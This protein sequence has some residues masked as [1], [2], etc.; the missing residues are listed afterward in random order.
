MVKYTQWAAELI[1]LKSAF[2]IKRSFELVILQLWLFFS[3]VT[4]M[5]LIF[6]RSQT[7]KESNELAER[8]INQKFDNFLLQQ[9]VLIDSNNSTK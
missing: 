6:A 5:N 7:A 9:L 3:L 2:L 8:Y 4:F 1:R